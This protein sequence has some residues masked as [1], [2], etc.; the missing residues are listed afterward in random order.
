MCPSSRTQEFP[1]FSQSACQAK[2]AASEAAACSSWISSYPA[3]A[4]GRKL[5]A[6]PFNG[7]HSFPQPD[8]KP[9]AHANLG[10][11]TSSSFL[12]VSFSFSDPISSAHKEQ[13]ICSTIQNKDI[14][15]NYCLCPVTWWCL[16]AFTVKLPIQHIVQTSTSSCTSLDQSQ[17]V[18]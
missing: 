7:F 6:H 8:T 3:P 5:C 15:N 12:S 16:R 1:F 13:V 17:T 2:P 4:T 18:H 11:V 14:R 10:I 9:T